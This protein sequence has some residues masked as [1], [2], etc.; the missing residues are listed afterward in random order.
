MGS[1]PEILAWGLMS[2]QMKKGYALGRWELDDYF[3]CFLRNTKQIEAASIL[4]TL[5]LTLGER[6]SHLIIHFSSGVAASLQD[7]QNKIRA[8][9]WIQCLE[10]PG[11]RTPLPLGAFIS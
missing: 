6:H 7:R 10:S 9:Q 11:H 1:D 4:P 2:L 8:S 5:G 3:C